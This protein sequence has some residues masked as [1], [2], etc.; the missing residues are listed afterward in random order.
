[1]LYSKKRVT[2][3]KVDAPG[4]GFN[5]FCSQRELP[6]LLA[7]RVGYFFRLLSLLSK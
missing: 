3:H 6:I 4:L 1:M 7:D 5:L 2:A